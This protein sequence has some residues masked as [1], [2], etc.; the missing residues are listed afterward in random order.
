VNTEV[1]VV[2]AVVSI[3]VAVKAAELNVEG[4][5]RL[6][7]ATSKVGLLGPPPVVKFSRTLNQQGF[8][9]YFN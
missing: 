2:V 6:I 3:E 4:E 5:A 7:E 8:P 9:K 1:G